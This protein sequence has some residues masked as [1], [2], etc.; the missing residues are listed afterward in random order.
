MLRLLATM[1]TL[2]LVVSAGCATPDR[3]SASPAVVGDETLEATGYT[4]AGEERIV[5]TRT[6]STGDNVTV[7]S[8]ARSYRKN[9][10]IDGETRP[11]A[12][13]SV[14][15]TPSI[16]FAGAQRNPVGTESP[17]E[18]LDRARGRLEDRI[19]GTVGTF[20]RTGNNSVTVLG[21][22]TTAAVFE[23]TVSRD[24]RQVNVTLELARVEHDGDFVVVAILYPTADGPAEANVSTMFAGIEHPD[25]E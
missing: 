23:T 11:A 3:F 5:E 20:E 12:V 10:T 16:N 19:E 21:E 13:L 15:S 4:L 14:L 6:V 1:S 24:D 17:R 22:D 7:V 2:A 9:V 8:Y 25:E 18:L